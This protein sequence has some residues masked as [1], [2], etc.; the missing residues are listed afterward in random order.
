MTIFERIV[1]GEIPY[2]RVWENE[3]FLALLD[4]RQES[5]A[6]LTELAKKLRGEG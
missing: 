5:A 3:E 6:K 1:S 4:I 2:H